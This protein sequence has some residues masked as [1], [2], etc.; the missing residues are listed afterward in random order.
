[1]QTFFINEGKHCYSCQKVDANLPTEK[2]D[3]RK[4]EYIEYKKNPSYKDV[5]FDVS[6]GGLKAT[7]VEHNLD[8][9]KGWYE[10]KVQE[11]GYKNGHKV[12]LEKEN[13][14]VMY[15]KNTEGTW[16]DKLFEIAG[17]ETALPS[18]IRNALKHCATKPDAEI[19][20]IFFPN[21]NFDIKNFNL[22]YK[23]FKGLKGT[24]QYRKF[25]V[26]Y[27]LCKDRVLLT[28]KPG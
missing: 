28:K 19:A 5:E 25:K 14:A 24:S 17:A 21:D 15:K 6:S 27:C 26:I 4:Q 20:V 22:G 9:K 1:M 10:T 8:K 11:V 18:N 23:K 12:I 3:K 13:H 16:D 7:H 2:K